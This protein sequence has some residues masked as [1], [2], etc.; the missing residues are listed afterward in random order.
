MNRNDFIRMIEGTHPAERQMTGEINELIGMFPYF[1]SAH[2]LLLRILQNAS[3]IRFENQLR[4][5]AIHI[6]DR[7]VLY[8]LLKKDHISAEPAPAREEVPGAEVFAP[9]VQVE[10]LPEEEIPAPGVQDETIP[11]D[12][13]P[14]PVIHPE[15]VPEE[16]APVFQ[17]TESHQT[18]IES[19]RNSD[20]L[21]N[22]FEKEAGE[23]AP[24]TSSRSDT[25]EFSQSILV[26][27]E[28]DDDAYDSSVFVIGEESLPGEER[29]IYMD[30]GFSVP[31]EQDLLE[32]EQ[33]QPVEEE[34]MEAG[35]DPPP[36]E[37]E[38]RIFARQLQADLIDRFISANPR[39]EAQ[40]VKQD[41]PPED[42]SGPF[43]EEK[44]GF[45]SETLARIYINQ[46][47]Y[48][49]AID[50]YEKLILKFP[51]KSSYFAAQIEKVKELIK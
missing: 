29:I 45:V 14:P 38:E 50:I 51:E 24:D 16:E 25:P 26:Y 49:K 36:P 31:E 10:D 3:D 19:A 47:Y 21:I 32:L 11:E 20:D 15:P 6:A 27:A 17:E 42:M 13:V 34:E 18:V 35:E 2:M 41:H 39:I 7:E 43:V 8:H 48:S 40:T 12:E 30:P 9:A 22:E 33:D 23:T 37:Y 1:Q 46:G 44:G 28:G 4:S 5:S